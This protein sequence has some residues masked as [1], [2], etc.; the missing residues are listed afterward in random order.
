MQCIN[1]VC[2]YVDID[3]LTCIFACYSIIK[4]A[5]RFRLLTYH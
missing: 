3:I 4:Y 1:S 2:H 5:S